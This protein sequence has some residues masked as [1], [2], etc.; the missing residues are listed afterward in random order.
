ME[1]INIVEQEDGSA[2]IELEMTAEEKH[3]LM[4]SA[5]IIGL[6][7]GL[8]LVV[9]KKV[10]ELKS[11][12]DLVDSRCGEFGGIHGSGEQPCKSGEQED[13]FKTSQVLG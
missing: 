11:K 8:K 9:E 5:F 3:H 13:G 7:E 1:V 12:T 6:T 10:N 2:I 4:E